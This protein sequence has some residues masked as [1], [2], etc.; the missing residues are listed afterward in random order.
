MTVTSSVSLHTVVRGDRKIHLIDTPGFDDNR[1]S[2]VD[3][4]RE[5]AFWLDQAH[6]G[7][8]KLG[9]ILYLHRITDCRLSGSALRGLNTFKQL[10]GPEAFPGVFMLTTFWESVDNDR[11]MREHALAR[12]R[13]LESTTSFWG[14]IMTVGGQSRQLR[15]GREAALV[16]IDE[17]TRQSH[18]LTLKIQLEM[19]VQSK[20]LRDTSAGRVLCEAHRYDMSRIDRLMERVQSELVEALKNHHDMN[21]CDLR[22]H[23]TQLLREL[24]AHTRMLC[25]LDTPIP[26]VINTGLERAQIERTELTNQVLHADTESLIV[27]QE[28]D[29]SRVRVAEEVQS[30]QTLQSTASARAVQQVHIP[31]MSLVKAKEKKPLSR[32]IELGAQIV[33]AVVGTASLAVTAAACTVM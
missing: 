24:E 18:S 3:V 2:D 31:S 30:E 33:S 15:Q 25:E 13:E 21:I 10:C 17:L 27:R 12:Q 22:Q 26:E 1:S 29:P 8:I 14:E 5:M 7:G 20:M 6:S 32:K 16:I 28:Q 4:L 9:G 11:D 19:A 23:K